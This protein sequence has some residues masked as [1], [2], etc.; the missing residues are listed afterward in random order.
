LRL[1]IDIGNSSAKLIV[2]DGNTI[3][4]RQNVPTLQL[5]TLR[6]LFQQHDIRATI[7]SSVG[8]EYP[9]IE[10]WLEDNT[11]FIRLH[12]LTPLPIENLYQTPK[13]LGKDRIAAAVGANALYPY[14]N[15]LVVDAGTCITYEFVDATGKYRGGS[16]APG[17]RMRMQAMHDYTARLPLIKKQRLD[18][19]VGFNTETA[20]RTGAQLGA[21][22][23]VEG[24]LNRYEQLYGS[25]QLII[26]GGDADTI[27][28]P[29]Q[30][31]TYIIN[32]DLVLIGLNKILEYNASILDN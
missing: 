12:H 32:K 10:H 4:E 15:C 28:D 26:T 20:M 31:S 16:I 23:E 2:F 14:T 13:T 25:V 27:A 9:V 3:V 1:A 17:I 24:F 29:L 5:D 21:S 19:F 18:S 30:T 22:L 6:R 11:F 7:V 8:K